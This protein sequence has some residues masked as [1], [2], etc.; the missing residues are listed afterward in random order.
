M[1]WGLLG[2]SA[3]SQRP[4]HYDPE[5]ERRREIEDFGLS[6]PL[7]TDLDGDFDGFF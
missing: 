3:S 1:V 5:E 4:R 2:S 7:D 6:L